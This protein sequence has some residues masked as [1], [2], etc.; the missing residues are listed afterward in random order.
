M[1]KTLLLK[2]FERYFPLNITEV[3]EL[4]VRLQERR[5]KRKQLLLHEN[6]VCNH[7]TFVASGCFRMYKSDPI[8]KEH[9]IEFV[10][11]N[12]WITDIGSLYKRIPSKLNIEAIEPSIILQIERKDLWYLYTHFHS[13][14]RNFR[15]IIEDKYTQLQDRIFQHISATSQE[16]YE[17]FLQNYPH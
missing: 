14:D 16:H 3:K 12:D 9:S 1:N 11:E 13:F 10:A 5:V 6:E 17:V 2:H 15:V 8:G 4:L 7:I